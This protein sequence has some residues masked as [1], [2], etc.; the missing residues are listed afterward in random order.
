MHSNAKRGRRQAEE[1]DC[2]SEDQD[3][4]D[5]DLLGQLW[6]DLVDMEPFWTHVLLALL[7][8]MLGTCMLL[9]VATC[10]GAPSFR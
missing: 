7:E 8:V 10:L 6:D 1:G 2:A 5:R 4:Q 9:F 3:E